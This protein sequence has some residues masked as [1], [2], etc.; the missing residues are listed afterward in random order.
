[1]V[2][3]VFQASNSPQFTAGVVTLYT[4]TAAPRP[5]C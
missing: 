2:G 4:V 5:A 1:M 3:G